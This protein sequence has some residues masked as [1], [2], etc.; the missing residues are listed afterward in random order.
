M[1]ALASARQ[2]VT[3]VERVI[4][5][6]TKLSAQ[7][8]EEGKAEAES[9]DKFACFCKDE[10]DKKVYVIAKSDK[11]INELK[12][13]IEALTG[14]IA[15]L[16]DEAATLAKSIEDEEATQKKNTEA[17]NK[18]HEEYQKER[19]SLVQAISATERAMEAVKNSKKDVEEQIAM[20]LQT[21]PAKAI[22]KS[23]LLA[24]IAGANVGAKKHKAA[25]GEAA[26]YKY[27]SQEV[28]DTLLMLTREFKEDLANLDEFEAT[29]QNSFE[30][31]EGERT[32]IIKAD[33]AE[34][35]QKEKISAS[36]SA[37]KSDKEMQEEAETADRNS[38]Q[39]FLDALT[40]KCEGKA[41]AWD[42]RSTARAEEITTLTQAVELLKG[43]GEKYNANSKL[44]G[45]I[46]KG[47]QP[48]VGQHSPSS[49]FQLRAQ[50]LNKQKLSNN[51]VL[52][53]LVS[54]LSDKAHSLKSAPLAM[55]AV[56]IESSGPDHFVKVRGIIKDLIDKLE[57]DAKA[58]ATQK[59]F[60]DKEMA[61]AITKRDKNAAAIEVANAKIDTTEAAIAQL[62]VEIEELA[63]QIAELHA[64]LVEMKKL[65]EEEK[66]KNEKTIADAK[67]GGE[68]VAQALK[69]LEAYYG[70]TVLMQSA[71]KPPNSDREGKTV[72]DVMKS[73]DV[74]TFKTEEYKGQIDSSKGIIGMLEVIESDFIRT[75]ETVTE[76]EKESEEAY[77]ELKA[78]TEK[79]IKEKEK[80]KEG[81][82]ADKEEQEGLL[83]EYKDDL[84]TATTKHEESLEELAKIKTLCV[85][86][87]ETY[88]ERR[89]RRQEE[90]EALKEALAILEDWKS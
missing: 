56:Q 19:D 1:L 88:A 29:T 60:C 26:K 35:E 63:K 42:Q 28:I 46:S 74:E 36:K 40:S 12:T 89:Q 77:Q 45:L 47:T 49:F 58:E 84:E 85:D 41:E 65:R 31:A 43:I 79:S 66:A 82:E 11:L 67:D 7:V 61:A 70:T 59:S 73:Q 39:E 57:A 86:A 3:P 22:S 80:D 64:T 62:K 44:V 37:E 71:Y 34:K 8:Q 6:L 9:Y 53:K 13:D 33:K 48:A 52:N 90:I 81:K 21:L 50:S 16:D 27:D 18:E 51:D 23:Q 2:A 78:E 38:D 75:V 4:S 14:E 30:M 24:L 15:A 17:R 55:L 87:D 10:A 5:L 32:N 25:P 83:L 68:A 72:D 69:V 20:L 76:Q 54:D